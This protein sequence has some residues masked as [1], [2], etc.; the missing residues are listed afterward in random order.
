MEAKAVSWLWALESMVSLKVPRVI[1][2]GQETDV[3]GMIERPRAW[4]SFMYYASAFSSLIPK[5]PFWRL[6]LD[7]EILGCFS[8]T[9]GI[10]HAETNQKTQVSQGMWI[11]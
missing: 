6:C 2:A 3:I 7:N 11:E 9:D 5:L 10:I 8:G 1:F 4:P